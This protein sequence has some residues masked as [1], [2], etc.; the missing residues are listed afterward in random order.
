VVGLV[1]GAALLRRWPRVVALCGPAGLAL[2]A[3]FLLRLAVLDPGFWRLVDEN[4]Q[5]RQMMSFSFQYL[6]GNFG[7]EPTLEAPLVTD[8]VWD[9]LRAATYLLGRGFWFGVGG[10]ALLVVAGVGLGGFRGWWAKGVAV[11]MVVSPGALLLTGLAGQYFVG[12]ADGDMAAGRYA[13]AIDGYETAQRFD[14]QLGRSEQIHLR[15]G[16]AHD[17]L[18]RGA[19]PAALFYLG[20]VYARRKDVDAAV[21]QFRVVHE[22][23]P[24]ALR[25]IVGRRLAW[26]LAEAGVEAYRRRL[27]GTAVGWWE[28]ALTV[29][30]DHLQ[31][32]YYLSRAYF[33]QGRY[34]ASIATSRSLLAVSRNRL[35]NSQIQT[36]IGDASWKL[37][38]VRSARAAYERAFNL[39]THK[40][41]RM[42]KSLGGT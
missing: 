8:T 17:R 32:A 15:L 29:D 2:A 7:I 41:Y 40:N 6:P 35:L 31:A 24:P 23:A 38:D 21:A 19:H 39:D 37:D 4:A 16:E 13:A 14:P 10:S 27:P 25:E 20:N 11:L 42:L 5:Y 1:A 33:D 36:T 30:R 3:F 18:G 28:R 9:R 22:V 34:D 12:R 26:T